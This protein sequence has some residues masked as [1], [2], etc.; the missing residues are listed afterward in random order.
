MGLFN[1]GSS[2]DGVEYDGVYHSGVQCGIAE[3]HISSGV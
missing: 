3:E 2:M 1:R